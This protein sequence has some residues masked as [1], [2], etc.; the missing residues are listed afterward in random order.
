MVKAKSKK[1][2]SPRQQ[3]RKAVEVRGLF[4]SRPGHFYINPGSIDVVAINGR[5][6]CG[7]MVR[8][9]RK[10]LEAALALMSRV[11]G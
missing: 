7:S 11:R 1:P 2:L 4:G 6:G 5:Y 10:Q 3:M 9:T 8:I